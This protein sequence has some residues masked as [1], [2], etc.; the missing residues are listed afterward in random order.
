MRGDV[1]AFPTL[2]GR[3]F[4]NEKAVHPTQKP[5]ALIIELIKAFCPKNKEGFSKE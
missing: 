2:A 5:E 4:K 1:W 3:A